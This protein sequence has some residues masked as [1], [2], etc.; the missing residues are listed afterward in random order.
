MFTTFNL[1][2]LLLGILLTVPLILGCLLLMSSS[3]RHNCPTKAQKV[4]GALFLADALYLVVRTYLLAN[5]DIGSEF[6][7]TMYYILDSTVI[8]IFGLVPYTIIFE[9]YPKWWHYLI[10]ISP[11]ILIPIVH[12]T[13]LYHLASWSHLIPIAIG[14]SALVYFGKYAHKID[15]Q[16][17]NYFAD[18][19]LHAKSWV[20][21]ISIGYLALTCLSMIRYITPGHVWFNMAIL[22]AWCIIMFVLFVFLVRQ[23]SFYLSKLEDI[24]DQ[25]FTKNILTAS[26]KAIIS[27]KTVGGG[28]NRNLD[29]ISK[30]LKKKCEEPQLYLNRD[31]SLYTLA[32]AC[33]TN[34]TYLTDYL[35]VQLHQTFY[36]Y[37]NTL[38]LVHVDELLKNTKLP[39]EAIALQCGFNSAQTMRSAYLKLR[40]KELSRPKVTEQ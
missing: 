37:I 3:L 6:E 15:Q 25:N 2:S 18:P 26:P 10:V 20:I 22:M 14:T 7:R 40:G 13:N 33:G 19:E 31:L 27:P 39:Q 5:N 17:S 12:C 34:R 36:D 30:A 24:A 29:F 4:A 1:T 16:L 32:R 8:T 21:Y 11:L 38:R 35:H 9:K 23:R 28:K